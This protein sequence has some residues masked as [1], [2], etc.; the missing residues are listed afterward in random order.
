MKICAARSPPGGASRTMSR[1]CVIVAPSAPRASRCGSRRRRPITSPPG[2]G[3][4]ARPKRASRGPAS[5]NEARIFSAAA[6]SSSASPSTSLAQSV[7]SLSPVHSTATPI[8]TRSISIESTSLMRGTLPITTRSLVSSDAA[9]I[10][11]APF[12]FPAGTTVPLSGTPPSIT[13]V[14]IAIGVCSCSAALA[15]RLPSRPAS[16]L[17]AV[18]SAA[19]EAKHQCR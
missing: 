18:E 7:T 15:P 2:G 3:I 11:S 14:S 16:N 4:A 19:L 12:L 17:A 10:G 9:R 8:P 13:K 6:R 1:P 5:R